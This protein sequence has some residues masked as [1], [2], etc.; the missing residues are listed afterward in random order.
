[1]SQLGMPPGITLT[2]RQQHVLHGV[3]EGFSNKE[4]AATEG[5]SEGAIKATLQQ[6]FRKAQVRRR[7][8]LVRLAIESTL[9]PTQRPT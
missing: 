7:T 2:V 8:Q 6:I 3:C 9:V 1:M 5:V 4:I